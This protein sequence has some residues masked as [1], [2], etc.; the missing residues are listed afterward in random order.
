MCNIYILHVQYKKNYSFLLSSPF[1]SKKKSKLFYHCHYEE[2]YYYYQIV[3]SQFC[4][5]ILFSNLYNVII[6]CRQRTI[7]VGLHDTCKSKVNRGREQLGHSKWFL[8]Q[9]QRGYSSSEKYWCKHLESPWLLNIFF[10]TFQLLFF[11][12]E[13]KISVCICCEKN[14]D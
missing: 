10:N 3:T 5:K 8:P 4:K 9:V 7:R 1:P 11:V 12:S 14:I 13:R 2:K 6:N